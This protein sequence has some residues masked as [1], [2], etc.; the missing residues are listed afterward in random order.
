M[1][2]RTQSTVRVAPKK[3]RFLRVYRDS[4]RASSAFASQL[5][6]KNPRCPTCWRTSSVTSLRCRRWRARSLAT[7]IISKSR[8]PCRNALSAC[9]RSVSRHE[10]G[11]SGDLPGPSED[12]LGVRAG[13]LTKGLSVKSFKISYSGRPRHVTDSNRAVWPQAM[14]QASDFEK[15]ALWGFRTLFLHALGPQTQTS[16]IQNMNAERG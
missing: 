2:K 12:A 6:S 11:A 8:W 7:S 13:D 9:D 15:D 16:C 1:I 14:S 3:R 4:S 5:L 10:L